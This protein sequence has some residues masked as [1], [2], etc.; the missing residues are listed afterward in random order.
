MRARRTF[1]QLHPQDGPRSL[2]HG[3][4]PYTRSQRHS[5]PVPQLFS[6]CAYYSLPTFDQFS[7]QLEGSPAFAP[8]HRAHDGGHVAVGGEMSNFFSS[9]GGKQLIS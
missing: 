8:D 7:V 9:P 5:Q 6:H 1:R 3:P 4:L 2:G